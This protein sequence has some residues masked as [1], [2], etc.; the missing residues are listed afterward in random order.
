MQALYKNILI[1]IL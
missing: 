1:P